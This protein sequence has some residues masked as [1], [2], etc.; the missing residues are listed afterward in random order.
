MRMKDAGKTVSHKSIVIILFISVLLHAGHTVSAESIEIQGIENIKL[1]LSEN[2]QTW[3]KNHRRIRAGGPVNFPPFHFY[4]EEGKAEGIA[5]D[6][7][8]Y[9]LANIGV[10]IETLSDLPWPEVLSKAENKELDLIA[11][12][13]KSPDREKYLLFSDAFLS[14][15]LVIISSDDSPFIGGLK[16]LYDLRVALVK[17]NIVYEWLKE[18]EIEVIPRFAENP[19]DAL[20]MVSSGSADAYIGNLA[21][22]S[23]FIQ[24]Y[25]YTNLKIAAPTKYKNYDLYI[26]VRNDWPELVSIINKWLAA[27]TPSQHSAIRNSWLSVKYEYGIG[28]QDILR[29]V[30]F[31]SAVFCL[32]IAAIAVWNRRLK[33]EVESRKQAETDKERVIEELKKV[34]K[35]LDTIGGLVPICSRC[36]KVRDDRGYWN[37]LEQYFEEHSDLSFS[38]GICP[39]CEQDLYKNEDWYGKRPNY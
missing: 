2:E 33:I 5:A 32:I 21:A 25:G 6:Y 27:L 1:D 14:F 20:E 9:I 35:D 17:G 36:K 18:D 19:H 12:S 37:Q 13:A 7:I 28:Y 16:D 24:K 34:L 15:P 22:A 4:S 3:I 11:C 8:R 38:H 10:E 30:I 31:I 39:E 23:Y 26:S 29:Y